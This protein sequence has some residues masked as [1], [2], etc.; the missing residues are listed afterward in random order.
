MDEHVSLGESGNAD[1]GR[2]WIELDKRNLYNNISVL[3]GLMPKGCSMM[4]AVK[5]NAYGH[6]AVLIAKALNEVGIRAFCVASAK[7]GIELRK[8]GILG[9][10]LILG[11]THPSDFPFLKKYHLMQTVVDYPYAKSLDAFGEKL[12]VHIKIDTG[13]HRLGERAEH[14]DEIYNMFH[15]EHLQIDGIFT[16]L[17]AADTATE[18]ARDFTLKQASAFYYLLTQLEK[19]G[20]VCPK[21]HLQSSDGLINYPDLHGDYVRAGIAIY[22]L[23]S[24]RHDVEKCPV[25]LLPVL[26]VKARIAAIK[27]LYKGETAGYGLCYVADQNRKIAVLSI[28]YADGLPRALSGGMGKVLINGHAAPVIGNICMDQTLVDITDIPDVKQGDI[29]VIIGTS[30]N[31]EISAYD[32]AESTGT[33]TNEV[34]SRLGTRLERMMV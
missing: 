10:I 3:S 21:I 11:Y 2:A 28:G 1:K 24:S 33:I 14:I 4:P 12:K 29:A 7:E 6:G 16:H 17:C 18:P 9:D 5:A 15:L 34:L 22:G 30:G 13:M 27:D 8:N 23:L 31:L 26:S 32:I 25:S 20:I 19:R